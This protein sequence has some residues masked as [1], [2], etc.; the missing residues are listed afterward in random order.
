[1]DYFKRRVFAYIVDFF[2]VSAFMWI[3]SYVLY[4]FVNFYNIFAIYHYFI[5]VL[6]VIQILYFTILEKQMN[7]TIGKRMF[8]IEV[9]TPNRSGLSYSQTFV[10]N[11][12]KIYWVPVILDLIL[13]LIAKKDD[14]LLSYITRTYIRV[15]R[16]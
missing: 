2:V 9:D 12:S 5:F 1:M 7:A 4:L 16:E 15:E 11:I 6:P 13:G 3:I 14:R 8:Y 10:R